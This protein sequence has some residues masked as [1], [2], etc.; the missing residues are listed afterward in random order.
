VDGSP[1]LQGITVDLTVYKDVSIGS[2]GRK[3]F[4]SSVFAE[5]SPRNTG[6]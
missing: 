3:R 5:M 4:T 1:L 2:G 6:R